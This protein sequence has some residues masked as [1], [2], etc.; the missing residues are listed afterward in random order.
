MKQQVIDLKFK[1]KIV[2]ITGGSRGIGKSIAKKFSSEGATVVITSK[3]KTKLQQTA[4]ELGNLFFIPGDIRDDGDV[5]NVVKKTIEKFDRIDILV[6]NAGI[7]PTLKSIDKISPSLSS[8]S[9]SLG[10]M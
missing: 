7:L 9:A 1:N 8:L 5:Q 3:N 2:L 4:K 10:L 6:N